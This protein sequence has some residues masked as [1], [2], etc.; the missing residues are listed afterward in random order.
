MFKQFFVNLYLFTHSIEF[1]I[2]ILHS[3][4][5]IAVFALFIGVLY[6]SVKIILFRIRVR[7][8]YTI[9]EIKP[10]QVTLQS[11]YSTQEFFNLIHGLNSQ[12][13]WFYKILGIRNSYSFEIV[14]TKSDGIRYLIRVSSE[15]V[16]FIK[17]SLYAY[18]P[19]IDIT[20]RDDYIP[21]AFGEINVRIAGFKLANHFAL[22]LKRHENLSEQ[23]PIAYITG[24]MTKLSQDELISLQIV[25]TPLEKKF[26]N[27]FKKI[28][29]LIYRNSDLVTMAT[30]N[31][32]DSSF[33]SYILK[34]SLFIFLN[35]LIFPLGLLVF[36]LSQ[37]KDGP[38]LFSPFGYL[39]KKTSNPY[40]EELEKIIKDKLDQQLFRATIRLLVMGSKKESD[41]R[42]N[43]FMASI[44]SFTNA[45]YQ[46]LIRTHDLNFRVINNL[47]IFLFINRLM[48]FR[49]NSIL[50][51][52]EISDIYHFPFTEV[53]KTENIQKVLSPELPAPIFL[54]KFLHF[55]TVIGKNNY[56][57]ST[58]MIGLNGEERRRHMYILGATGTGKSTLLFSMIK[59]DIESGK[60]VCVIDPHGDL[61]EN[62]LN[63]IPQERIKD[64]VYFNPD[65]ISFPIG[66]NLLELPSDITG[67]MLLREKELIAEG[68][69]SLFHKIYDDKYS[70]PRM[71][72]ILRNTIHTAFITTNPTLFT[73]YKL[74][75]N[76]NYRNK[77]ISKLEDE[78]LR[79]FWKYEF[80]KA[81]DFQKVKMISPITNK[82]G[83]FLF[84]PIAKRILEQEKSTINF[85]E[86]MNNGKILL[87]NVSKGKIGEDN[88]QIFGTLI[89]T[90]IQLAALKRAKIKSDLRRDFYLYV[91]EFQN[92]ATPSFAQI[93]SEARKYRLNAI[94]AHQTTSQLQDK[95][96][97]NVILANVGTTI[98]FRTA[99]P[100]DARLILPQFI[101]NVK[102][103]DIENLPSFHFYIKVSA[104]NP[105]EAFSGETIPVKVDWHKKNV[106][107]IINES[108][109]NFA[110]Y[111]IEQN[112][113]KKI[114]DET[115]EYGKDGVISK[116]WNIFP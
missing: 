70:G 92:F 3:L 77:V 1:N 57:G 59:Q 68:I 17:S 22:P 109:N 64:V 54:K 8:K 53:T 36:I 75:I 116:P 28:S 6:V 101:P 33:G 79:D 108:R 100:E 37:G 86:I 63:S 30:K 58:T 105:E 97:I 81:G 72:Y 93:L 95:S 38:F 102:A 50:S 78:N 18:L 82:I 9:L 5:L 114:N 44:V 71:E 66:L 42:I 60:G 29:S 2:L 111:F 46:S 4:F 98:S 16:S 69:I 65:D 88:S 99:N 87:C 39:H 112:G 14:S 90:K 20:I 31:S 62:I 51:S 27:D 103:G 49:E 73:I 113:I 43:G 107:K 40:Q 115:L 24:A 47:K 12:Q 41:K 10:L 85:D 76:E 61:I 13:F 32:P 26:V 11:P 83:R 45:S 80:A 52:S 89:M 19:G 104:I 55:D 35:I 48:G 110:T 96:L 21:T 91:D 23:D 25:L 67:D 56:G 15:E 84:S 106:E 74:L 34:S 7:G 94:L